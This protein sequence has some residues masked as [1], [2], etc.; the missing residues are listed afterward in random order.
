MTAPTLILVAPGTPDPQVAQVAH[1]LRAELSATRP[2]IS[3]HVAFLHAGLGPLD[4]IVNKVVRKGSTEVV[5][6][7]LDLANAIDIDPELRAA[8][9]HIRHAHPGVAVAAARPIGPEA[10]LLTVLDTRLRMALA[11]ARILELDGL[12]LSAGTTGD[13]RGTA[14]LARRAR[15]W[16]THHRLPCLIAVADGT[17]PSVAQAIQGLRSQGRRHIAVGSLFWAPTDAYAAQAELAHRSGA[18]AVSDALGATREV[19]DL[20]LARYAFAAMD[21]LDAEAYVAGGVPLSADLAESA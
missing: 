10:S 2:E 4:S 12:V 3:C 20:V 19:T 13:V 16:S 1:D 17:G 7:P 5:L 6:V 9:D 14:L 8:A 18:L 11:S 21:L 15:Q